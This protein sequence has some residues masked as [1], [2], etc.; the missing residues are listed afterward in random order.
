MTTAMHDLLL[1]E[2]L[3]QKE[4]TGITHTMYSRPHI[5]DLR[6]LN[7]RGVPGP[8]LYETGYISLI[9]GGEPYGYGYIDEKQMFPM[10]FKKPFITVG[11]KGLYEEL[12]RL[13]FK[14]F[15]NY[16]DI[17]FNEADTLKQ[18]VQGFYDTI[19]NLRKLDDTQFFDLVHSL[20]ND[21][22]HNFKNITTGNFRKNSNNQFLEE[23][24]NACG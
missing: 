12:E 23:V 20:K 13:N 9:P 19:E 14:T 7:D 5:I 15:K 1:K 4:V 18:R 6:D 21:V 2:K 16:W 17:S 24:I 8:W 10:Y 3:T 22:G 11:C